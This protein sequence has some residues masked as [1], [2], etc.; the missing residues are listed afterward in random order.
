MHG[1][2]IREIEADGVP[3]AAR[4]DMQLASDSSTAVSRSVALGVI[5]TAD[6]LAQLRPHLVVLLGD[7]YEILAA[8]I[9]AMTARVPIVHIHGGEATEGVIDEAIRHAVT[10]M[11]H[12]H[13]VA[14]E[15]YRARVL[16]MGESPDRV[17]NVGA[18]ALD[19]LRAASFLSRAE[20]ESELGMALDGTLIVL[21]YHPVTLEEDG[22]VASFRNIL[23]ALDGVAGARI[24]LTGTN[25]DPASSLIASIAHD[26][27]AQR[28]DCVRFV[29]SLGQRRYF[30][31]MRHADLMIGNSSSGIIEAPFFRLP[32]INVGDRQ[33]GRL[34]APSTI[35]VDGALTAIQAAL[36]RALDPAF[37]AGLS[38]MRHPY[39]SGGFVDR[40]I[41]V[42]KTAPLG[43]TLLK[44][45]FYDSA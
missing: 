7:R 23:L 10:K 37:R 22:G 40:A 6:A 17:T 9:A 8:A 3:I 2:T 27:A 29:S 20:L 32:T 14:A 34:A 26:Y 11:A 5:G 35:H 12:L 31:L 19:A 21:T 30:S 43:E 4:I 25:A 18:A 42:L 44:K 28:P 33:R 38:E 36:R 15:P 45:R 1:S 13:L 41:Q 16:R 24:V 39:D